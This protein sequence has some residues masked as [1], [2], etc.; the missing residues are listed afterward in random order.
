MDIVQGTSR[1][2]FLGTDTSTEKLIQIDPNGTI[3]WEH[4]VGH[5][6]FDLW[7]LSNQ[8]ILYCHYGKGPSGV[9]IIDHAGTVLTQYQT[10]HEIF[11]CQPLSDGNILVG[12]LR[13]KQLVEVD[14]A[15]DIVRKIPIFYDAENM[16]E[17]MRIPRKMKDGTYMVIQPGLQK[18]IRYSQTGEIL[19]QAK[20]R[21][22]A[23]GFVEKD[24][25]NIVYTCMDGLG[26][27]DQNGK[28][29]WSVFPEDIPQI[30]VKWLLGIQRL[31]NGNYV[32]CNWLGHNHEQEGI[33]MFEITPQKQ[34][35]WT[36]ACQYITENLANF[37]IL[38][39]DAQHVCF[40]PAR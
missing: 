10:E 32:C 4:H 26:E 39:E 40:R 15:G 33:P 18:I 13:Q 12:E 28:E 16:H 21:P 25:G 31:H 11:G 30:Q 35:V 8:N 7:V 27:L 38:N 9:R 19:W 17:V 37:Q 1:H 2:A 34:V 36:C 29:V 6:V 23:F 3:V 22:D 14:P 24:D 20:T 5:T